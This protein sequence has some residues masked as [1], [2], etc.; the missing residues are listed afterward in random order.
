VSA[1][2]RNINI[3]E[4]GGIENF[5]Q[6]DAAVNPGNSGGALV[7][8]S[9]QLMGIN[10]AIMTYSGQYEGFSFAIPANL[11]QKVLEDIRQYGSPKRGWLGVVI[12]PV[13]NEIA[14]DAGMTEITGVVL[15]KVNEGSAAEAAGLDE[16][17]II[18]SIDGQKVTSSPDFIGKVGQHHPGDIL[19]FAYVRDHK[20]QRNKSQAQ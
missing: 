14:D 17:D 6:T 7:S 19:T 18:L 10:T 20:K 13:N 12:R 16:G 9:G 5:I 4:E 1:K 8:T 3:L 15:E 11:A 2:A